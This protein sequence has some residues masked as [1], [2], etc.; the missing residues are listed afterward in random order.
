MF[1][2]SDMRDGKREPMPGRWNALQGAFIR[3]PCLG[4]LDKG[5]TE[6]GFLVVGNFLGTGLVRP[7]LISDRK[8]QRPRMRDGLA[9]ETLVFTHRNR[10]KSRACPSCT[11]NMHP[12]EN[13]SLIFDPLLTGIPGQGPAICTQPLEAPSMINIALL[14]HGELDDSKDTP[15][16]AIGRTN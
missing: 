14:P 13:R 12:A 1:D 6:G 15:G 9:K 2:I 8:H 11:S 4:H 3:H 5:V 16:R 7:T 10:C